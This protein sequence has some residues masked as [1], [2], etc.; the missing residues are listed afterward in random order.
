ME[1]IPYKNSNTIT[2]ELVPALIACKKKIIEQ[3]NEMLQSPPSSPTLLLALDGRCGSGKSSLALEL[4]QELPLNLIH[5]DDYYL[6]MADRDPDW[7]KQF[8]KNMN[9]TRLIQE[10]LQPAL[11]GEELLVRPYSCRYARYQD[12]VRLKP[13]PVTLI[14]GSYSLHPLLRDFYHYSIY[15]QCSDDTQR[16]RL[17]AREGKRFPFYQELWIPLEDAYCKSSRP[18][19]FASL[20][21]C[22]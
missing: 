2:T 9:F 18:D 19:S 15:L 13:K 10:I 5:M 22:S 17:I 4:A 14:E 6:P 20:T 8:G 7:K 11:K 3:V 16:Q 12:E 1:Q 21:C